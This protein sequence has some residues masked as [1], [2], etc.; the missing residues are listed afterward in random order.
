MQR[1]RCP[2][3]GIETELTPR[4]GD[5]IISAYCLKHTGGADAHTR[6]VYMT[7]APF[8][9]TAPEARVLATPAGRTAGAPGMVRTSPVRAGDAR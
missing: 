1:F 8:A 3:C 2:E 4:Y 5:E 7:R 6:P 9:G